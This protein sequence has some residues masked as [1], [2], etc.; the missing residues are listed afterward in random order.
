MT[1]R[2]QRLL[3][4][5]GLV[6]ALGV[7]AFGAE[8]LAQHQLTGRVVDER[9]NSLP[10]ARVSVPELG[11]TTSTGRQGEFTFPSLPAGE[12]RL[13]V[14]YLGLPTGV[15]GVNISASE[16]NTITLTL[17]ADADG[18]DRIV[19]TGSI[20]DGTARALNQQRTADGTTSIVSSDAIGRFP[21]ANIAEALQ[22]VPGFGIARDQGEGRYINLR[23]APSE[24]TAV[25]VDGTNLPSPDGS[26]RAIDLDTI[27][28]DVVNTIE[29]FKTLLPD[30]DADS[31]AGAVNLVTRSPF[32]TPRLRINA[33]GGASYNEFGGTNDYRSSLVISNV[34]GANGQFGALLSASYS[35]TDRQV[36]N[37]ESE[38]ELENVGGVDTWVVTE[39]QFKDYDTERTRTAFT[40]SL[41]YR[42]DD[43][44]RFFVRGSHSRFRD[45]EYRNLFLLTYDAGSIVTATDNT[46][47]WANT[48]FEKELRHR[49]VENTITTLAAGG[50]H[51][52]G[53]V[54]LD[55]TLSWALSEQSYPQRNQLQFRSTL[56]PTVS[57]DY[58]N[59]DQPAITIFQTAEHLN[60]GAYNF[61]RLDER[62]AD[63]RQ[64]EWAFRAN[65]Q[66]AGSLF[67]R[68][69]T[70]RFGGA[71]RNRDVS[72]DDERYRAAAAQA[73]LY[74]PGVPMSDLLGTEPSLNFNYNLGVKFDPRLVDAYFNSVRPALRN[75]PARLLRPASLQGDYTGEESIYAGYGM[76]RVEMANTTVI[77][78][79]RVE[80]TEFDGTG[81]RFSTTTQTAT[82]VS[83]SQSYTNWFPNLTVRHEFNENL[84]GRLAL[85][86][87]ISRPDYD[88]IVPRISANDG[89]GTRTVSLGNPDL[90]PTIANNFDAG[91]EYY[92][93][94]LGLIA[95]N[96]FYKDLEDYEYTLRSSGTFEGDPANFTRPE[97]APGGF[98]RGVELTWQ[99][100]FDFLPG[101][102]SNFG[103]F[104]NYTWTDSEM[105]LGRT[106]AGRSVVP[107]QGQSDYAYNV[108]L[109]YEADRF[110]ARLSYNDRSDYLDALDIEEPGR[111]LYWEGREQ[112]DFTAAFEVTS[113]F[114]LFLE[115]KNLTNTPGVRYFGERQR[116]YEYEEFGR[117]VF[118]GLRFNY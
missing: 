62:G 92:L 76:T 53:G 39:N 81:N 108:A 13:E 117:S 61:Q 73:G 110:S 45:D 26:T 7:S 102:M 97:N 57:Y 41:E 63:T 101:M 37:I 23:G 22:R 78:G 36:D 31:I 69:A 44:T 24:F 30:Q 98:I 71:Y 95:L 20:L 67:G 114:E 47:T 28:S 11:L 70:H 91:L 10:G 90:R 113:Q 66:F 109:F 100:T 72:F 2:N 18:V 115:A 27:P 118:V 58:S 86:R 32:D 111:D 8:A 35:R 82:P 52:F 49:T 65:A 68:S 89:P 25:S 83:A 54:E 4:V 56:R 21:D 43:A 74:G 94:P 59:P 17:A 75:D 9:G 85:T 29:V 55:Y 64:E 99:Q 19:I 79:L 96:A 51:D 6:L 40:G 112:L 15:R 116:V 34:F 93:R 12:A 42:P 48:R 106:I 105:E 5:S 88:D 50:E 104:A 38:W 80:H 16:A 60:L 107:L 46:A 3:G 87:A 103:V 84:V 14:D 1:I 33:S 77:A